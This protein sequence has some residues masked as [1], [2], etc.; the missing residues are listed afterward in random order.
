MYLHR[1][2]NSTTPH[3]HTS[4]AWVMTLSLEVGRWLEITF[5]PE[6]EDQTTIT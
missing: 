4:D 6:L 1:R 3:P 2:Y 5:S